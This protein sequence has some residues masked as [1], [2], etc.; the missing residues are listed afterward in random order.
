MFLL[1]SASTFR[2]GRQIEYVRLNIAVNPML[3]LRGTSSL[4]LSRVD[5]LYLWKATLT[6]LLWQKHSDFWVCDV[7]SCTLADGWSS[8]IR[9]R[10][11]C[12]ASVSLWIPVPRVF[13]SGSSVASGS[14]TTPHSKQASHS[15]YSSYYIW[16]YIL[17]CWTNQ[18]VQ[19]LVT[20]PDAN[21]LPD[22]KTLGIRTQSI[23][24]CRARL[25]LADEWWSSVSKSKRVNV[26]YSEV[27]MLLSE[28]RCQSCFS[29]I[30]QVNPAKH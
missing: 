9:K 18:Y 12:S 1:Y 6:T 8:F 5:L 19:N 23:N 11:S 20:L 13:A 28:Q 26:T 10:Q 25:P 29:E 7:D 15:M 27:R 22:G 21:E 3:P 4:M 17:L 30:K 2:L 14:K 24:T 16:L